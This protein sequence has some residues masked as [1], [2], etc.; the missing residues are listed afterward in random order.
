MGSLVFLYISNTQEKQ[1]RYEPWTETQEE[2][3]GKDQP[4]STWRQLILSLSFDFCEHAGSLMV[5]IYL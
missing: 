3:R 4:H 1:G 5:A 2:S